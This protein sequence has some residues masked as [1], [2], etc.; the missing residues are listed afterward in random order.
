MKWC[1]IGTNEMEG[2][3]YLGHAVF[4]IADAHECHGHDL[5]LALVQLE[6]FAGSICARLGRSRH[7]VEIRKESGCSMF[8]NSVEKTCCADGHMYVCRKI[9]GVDRNDRSERMSSAE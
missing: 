4:D 8:R 3:P 9:L 5:D 2:L 7:D 6:L 1:A